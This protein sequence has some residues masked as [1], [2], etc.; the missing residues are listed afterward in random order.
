MVTLK[1]RDKGGG[2]TWPNRGAQMRLIFK[3]PGRG[4][5]GANLNSAPTCQPPRER[6]PASR[7]PLFANVAFLR[8]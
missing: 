4:E 2:G 7:R 5:A 1:T 3:A 8:T 6:R